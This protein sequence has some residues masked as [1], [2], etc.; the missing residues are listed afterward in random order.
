MC[1]E[2]ILKFVD[3]EVD[4]LLFTLMKDIV[5]DGRVLIEPSLDIEIVR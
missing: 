4:D 1:F 5:L 2:E 3:A